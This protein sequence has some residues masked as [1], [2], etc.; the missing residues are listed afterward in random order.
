MTRK[1]PVKPPEDSDDWPEGDTISDF[2]AQP[3]KEPK[4]IVLDEDS[5]RKLPRYMLIVAVLAISFLAIIAF[6][7]S[8]PWSFIGNLKSLVPTFAFSYALVGVIV[9][10]AGIFSKNNKLNVEIARVL[11]TSA[12]ILLLITI[13]L[14]FYTRVILQASS[15]PL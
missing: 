3:K 10:G 5:V 14:E 1:E 4:E 12:G 11:F 7:L 9:I 8:N 13:A 6:H 2:S 15:G